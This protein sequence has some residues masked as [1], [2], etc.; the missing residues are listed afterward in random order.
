MSNM[1]KHKAARLAFQR[2][3]ARSDEKNAK[4][5]ASLAY[6]LPGLV[7]QNGLA[8]SSGFLLAKATK[9]VAHRQLHEDLLYVLRGLDAS[10]A[11]DFAAFHE[12]VLETDLQESILLTRQTLEAGAWLKRYAQALIGIDEDSPATDKVEHGGATDA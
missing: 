3:K 11:A 8:Q 10:R 7:L 5:Y 2:V 1:R 12:Q 6:K 9:N 4:E